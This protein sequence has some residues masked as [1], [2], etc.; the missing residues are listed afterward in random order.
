MRFCIRSQS[1]ISIVVRVLALG[2]P[3][4]KAGDNVWVQQ[5]RT[6]AKVKC[7]STEETWFLACNG[8]QWTGELG[9]CSSVTSQTGRYNLFVISIG[10]SRGGKRVGEFF[11]V[12]RRLG[13]PT[14]AQKYIC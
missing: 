7:N 12:P 3:Q 8:R 1:N 11:R 4:L 2:C 9:N 14:I 10:P 13:H 6:T 5:D